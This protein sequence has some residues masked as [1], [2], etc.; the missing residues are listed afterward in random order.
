MRFVRIF[1]K[2]PSNSFEEKTYIG[3]PPTVKH[4][5]PKRHEHDRQERRRQEHQHQEVLRKI[6]NQRILHGRIRLARRQHRV[7]HEQTKVIPMWDDIEWDNGTPVER[8]TNWQDDV[9][10]S[11]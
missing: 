8:E 5:Q 2:S 6:E 10:W 11:E 7:L 4:E 9:E 3:E 1:K